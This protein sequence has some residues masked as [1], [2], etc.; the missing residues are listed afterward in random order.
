MS[1]ME[2]DDLIEEDSVVL[3]SEDDGTSSDRSHTDDEET[4]DEEDEADETM[5]SKHIKQYIEILTKIAGDKY[6]YDNYVQLLEVAHEMAD[7]DKIRQ[8]AEIFAAMFPLSPDIWLRWLKIEA[9]LATTDEQVE[10]V[11]KLFI[12]ALTDYYSVDVATEFARLAMNTSNKEIAERIWKVLIPTY[13]LHTVK[14]RS[15][16]EAYR[17][18]VLTKNGD[19]AESFNRVARIYEQELKVPLRGMEDSCIEYKL[20]CEKY[21]SVLTD[22]DEEKF[23]RR[24]KQA[25]AALQRMIPHED[26]LA[27]LG[28]HEHQQRAELYRKY[29]ADCRSE[30]DDD[31]VQILY[32]RSVT[33][34]C[35]DATVWVDYL[36]YLHNCPPDV[37]ENVSPVFRQ[38]ELDLVNRA[39]RNCTWS[40]ELYVEKM[41]IVEREQQSRSKM[42]VVKIMEDV[43]SAGLQTPEASVKV[44]LEYLTF[45]RRHTDF[46]S[47]KEREILRANFDLAWNQLGR[48][49]GVLADPQCKIL[50]FWGRLEYEA[51]GEPNKGR[52][53]WLSVM[54]SADNATKAG[55]WIEFTELEAKRNTDAVRKLYRKAIT[56][57]GLD[58]PETLAA[59]WLR[60]ERCNGTLEQLVSCQELCNATIEKY[61][62]TFIKPLRPAGKGAKPKADGAANK[63]TTNAA[64]TAATTVADGS[65]GKKNLKRTH[66]QEFKVP[67]IPPANAESTPKDS[68]DKGSSGETPEADGTSSNGDSAAKRAKLNDP[69]LESRQVFI[70]NLSFEATEQD[71]RSAFPELSIESIELVLSSSGKSRGFGYMLLARESDVAQALSFDRRPLAGRPIF[72]SNVA[73]DKANRQHQ[74]K[75]ASSVEPNKLFIKGLPFELGKEELQRLF[76][77]FGTIRDIRIVCFRNG[78]SKGLAYLE[79]ESEAAAK[80]AVLKM[81]QHVI[82]GFTITVAISAP[83]PKKTDSAKNSG[84]DTAAPGTSS[85]SLGSG[86]RQLAK[87]D[88]KQKLSAMIPTAVLKRTAVGP[89]VPNADTEKPKSNDD[90]RKLLL[91]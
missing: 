68:T 25:K 75:Y 6:N 30:L 70:S 38:T 87:G 17:E 36:R 69:S 63:E 73:R 7:L 71:I 66:D 20:L 80:R 24:Y 16:F 4:E 33:E 89:P 58:D 39:L 81:D 10:N 78:R 91:K 42:T 60:F 29:I 26:A 52:D 13:G 62:S 85:A 88:V 35:L 12:R 40:A 37:D 9:P 14:G 72:I 74:F 77:P 15:I 61:Y 79:Y 2:T 41:R 8:S 44:W 57:V 90:F 51:L 3:V 59:A 46:K 22:L 48:T 86:K 47:E 43:A 32:E 76:E 67:A 82:D 64:A 53:L 45:L 65:T 84:D 49:W 54:E 83:P 23:E 28:S 55:L 31:E 50:Q 27:A 18:D 56:T 21:K 19:S 1:S 5:E 11:E 34:C